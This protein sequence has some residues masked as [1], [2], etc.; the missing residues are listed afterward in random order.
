MG[1]EVG[2]W[3]GKR[4]KGSERVKGEVTRTEEGSEG[5]PKRFTWVREAKGEIMSPKGR[6]EGPKGGKEENGRQGRTQGEYRRTSGCLGI[7][8]VKGKEVG[9]R[10]SNQKNFPRRRA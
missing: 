9:L 8:G 3:N 10:A 1:V 4:Y 2:K 7:K 5:R 6:E